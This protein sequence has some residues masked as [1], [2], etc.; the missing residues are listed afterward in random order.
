MNTTDREDTLVAHQ[1]AQHFLPGDHWYAPRSCC[2]QFWII[3]I[4]EKSGWYNN[5]SVDISQVI[6]TMTNRYWHTN[7]LQKTG[8]S[9]G[10]H[11]AAR[12][13]H[14]VALSFKNHLRSRRDPLPAYT[15]KM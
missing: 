7:S 1:L 15:H 11:I 5:Q 8:G 14:T 12:H 10:M 2:H 3:W 13:N 6:G 4:E 9:R